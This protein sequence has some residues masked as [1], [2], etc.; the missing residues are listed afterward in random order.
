MKEDIPIPARVYMGPRKAKNGKTVTM[1][2]ALVP[3]ELANKEE[4]FVG[5]I[6]LI[7]KKICDPKKYYGWKAED[8]LSDGITP[9]ASTKE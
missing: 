2:L 1:I 5:D 6:L 4:M 7:K 8:I 9:T 3:D